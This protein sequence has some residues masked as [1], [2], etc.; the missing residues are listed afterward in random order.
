MTKILTVIA[1]LPLALTVV[2]ISY[3]TTSNALGQVGFTELSNFRNVP[4]YC[5]LDHAV[6]AADPS[7]P[8]YGDEDSDADKDSEKDDKDEDQGQ[9]RLWDSVLLG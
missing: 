2:T 5:C 1:W 4:R 7:A 3:P 8:I 9:N 6:V